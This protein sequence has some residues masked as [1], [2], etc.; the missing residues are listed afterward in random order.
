MKGYVFV[1]LLLTMISSSCVGPSNTH[2]TKISKQYNR[3]EYKKKRQANIN[4]LHYSKRAWDP[5]RKGFFKRL[6]G[7]K[8]YY[9]NQ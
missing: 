5:N 8:D 9:A 6:F 1:I 3:N 7:K 2:K 4:S